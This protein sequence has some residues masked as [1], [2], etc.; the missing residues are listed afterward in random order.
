MP[1]TVNVPVGFAALPGESMPPA[2]TC[3]AP[4]VPVPPRVPPLSTV[5]RLE[6][7]IEPLTISV[8]EETVH[9]VVTV[10]VPVS[11][12]V[13]ASTFL[14]VEKPV[15]CTPR[16]P[17]SNVPA[18]VPPSWNVFVPLATT[19]PLITDPGPSV[20][21]LPPEEKTMAGPLF[22]AIVPALKIEVLPTATIA[23][24]SPIIEPPALLMMVP[25]LV[26][27]A[28]APLPATTDTVPKFVRLTTLPW[29]APLEPEL[30]PPRILPKW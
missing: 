5:V 10:C 25:L 8:P 24:K 1:A 12:Q 11:V 14:K 15:Y 6:L 28:G 13:L 4:T 22:V 7:A 18:P 26:D 29:M 30:M 16:V 2:L 23:L 19:L 27:I 3:V 9:G 17:A 20:R 21:V